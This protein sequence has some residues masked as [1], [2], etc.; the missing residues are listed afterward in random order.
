MTA[1]DSQTAI[2]TPAL[3]GPVRRFLEP[4]RFAIAATLNADGSPIQAVIWYL[5]D[6]DEIVFNSRVGR[7][8]PS[9]LLRDP[10]VSITVADDYDY[11][12]LRG[13]V[14]IDMDPERGQ[15]VIAQL[16]RRYQRDSAL[17]DAQIARFRGEQRVTFR[18]RPDKVFARLSDS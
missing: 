13:D 4:P 16:A 5:I 1:I 7:R 15:A 10:R 3:S 14:E 2:Y 9:N 11:I 18:L 12:D 6:G 8:W 17:V